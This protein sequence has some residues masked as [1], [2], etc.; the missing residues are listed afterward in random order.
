[1]GDHGNIVVQESTEHR[2]YLYGHWSGYDMPEI[3]RAALVRGNGR[4]ND[5]QY[6][7]RIIFCELVKNDP[8]GTTGYGISARV[9]DN[10]YPIIVVDCEKQEIRLEAESDS[11]HKPRNPKTWPMADYAKLPAARWS[12][13]D[14]AR[15]EEEEDA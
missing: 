14:E 8:N 13:L 9:H 3:L 7:A 12:T 6:L 2:V 4:W 5:P 1:M 10:E 15:K 11:T